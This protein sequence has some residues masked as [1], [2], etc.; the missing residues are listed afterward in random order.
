[1]VLFHPIEKAQRAWARQPSNRRA[2]IRVTELDCRSFVVGSDDMIVRLPV[3]ELLSEQAI[4]VLPEPAL[5]VGFPRDDT[6]IHGTQCDTPSLHL[7]LRRVNEVLD[8]DA[9]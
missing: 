7:K 2:A 5:K 8:S 9:S 3:A 6:E 1:M 4:E